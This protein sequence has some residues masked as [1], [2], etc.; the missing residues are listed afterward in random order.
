MPI[1]LKM[2]TKIQI[3]VNHLLGLLPVMK[4]FCNKMSGAVSKNNYISDY[5]PLV[6]VKVV[7]SV[8]ID[9]QTYQIQA[10]LL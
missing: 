4:S 6:G 8:K 3:I 2:C 7:I 10:V 5:D 1:Y 9:L